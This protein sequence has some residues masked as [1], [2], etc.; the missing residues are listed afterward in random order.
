LSS[1]GSNNY[2][3]AGAFDAVKDEAWL[4]GDFIATIQQRG[5]A[6]IDKRGASSAASAA[7]AI[8]EHVHDWLLGAGEEY[9]SMGVYTDE[10]KPYGVE[11][12]LIYSFPLH[13]VRGG[14][15]KIVLG[16]DVDDFSAAKFK[17]T[18]KELEEVRYC[19]ITHCAL[20]LMY[21]SVRVLKH[22]HA[23]YT[24]TYTLQERTMAL[25]VVG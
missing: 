23:F 24:H 17:A 12:N 11:S 9:V 6:V 1:L 15:Y 21:W 18:E 7:N 16:L 10:S 20:L 5:K 3:S 25:A 4:K 14:H 19:F 2:A 22:T 8:I 13:T